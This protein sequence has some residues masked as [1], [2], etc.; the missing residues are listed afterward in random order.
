MIR[1]KRARLFVENFGLRLAD[2]VIWPDYAFF[3]KNAQ[4]SLES[5]KKQYNR[6]NACSKIPSHSFSEVAEVPQAATTQT[7]RVGDIF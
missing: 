6:Q 7:H 2:I 5:M 1:S 4:G 3:E